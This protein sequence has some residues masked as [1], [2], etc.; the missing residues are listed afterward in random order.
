M[1]E[2]VR[3]QSGCVYTIESVIQDKGGALGRVY[4]AR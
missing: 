1:A 2:S 3:G 4:L